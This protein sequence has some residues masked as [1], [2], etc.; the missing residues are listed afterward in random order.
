[1]T[2]GACC[3]IGKL[4]KILLATDMSTDSEGAIREA[5]KFASKCSSKIYACMTLETNP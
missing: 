4:D 1:M 2:N 5:I 3:P